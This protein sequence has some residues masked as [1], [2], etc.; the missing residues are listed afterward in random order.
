VGTGPCAN[1][2]PTAASLAAARVAIAAGEPVVN[3]SPNGCIRLERTF[4]D[5][6]PAVERTTVAGTIVSEYVHTPT[7]MTGRRDDDRDGFFESEFEVGDGGS[8]FRRRDPATKA[9]KRRE[10]R[11][12]DGDAI[13]VVIE[14]DGEVVQQFRATADGVMQASAAVDLPWEGGDYC[15]PEL[16]AYWGNLLMTAVHRMTTCLEKRGLGDVA[17]E[18]MYAGTHSTIVCGDLWSAYAAAIDAGGGA[19]SGRIQID[20]EANEHELEN[21]RIQTLAHELLHYTSLGLHDSAHINNRDSRMEE[22]DRVYACSILCADGATSAPNKCHCATCLQSDVCDER[23]KAEL[24]CKDPDLGAVCPCLARNKW[25]P[26]YL[27]CV[28]DCSSGL[29]CFGFSKC[30]N[31]SKKC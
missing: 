3:L 27:E 18:V 28:E 14:E 22:G 16:D 5:G 9:V 17:N 24:E 15:G 6:S 29:I 30:K 10:T 12:N 26:T 7:G 31:L 2:Y 21:D 19:R 1:D 23:C 4:A 11:T 20:L 8:E 25:Y 13:L